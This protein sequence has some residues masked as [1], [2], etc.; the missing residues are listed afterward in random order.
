NA[1]TWDKGQIVIQPLGGA[2]KTLVNGGAD[3]RYLST[4]HLIYAFGGSLLAVAFDVDRLAVSGG[5]VPV[6]EGVQ[7]AIGTPQSAVAQFSASTTGSIAYVPGPTTIATA[8]GTDLALF[9]RKGGA[10]PLKLPKGPFGSPRVTRDG[11]WIA[12]ERV[13]ERD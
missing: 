7:R 13:D 6:V 5:A 10:E 12:F 8:D 11:K 9:D 1:D 3:A 2:R 4:G